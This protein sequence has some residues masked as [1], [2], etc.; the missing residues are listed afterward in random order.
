MAAV[1]AAQAT[2]TPVIADGGIRYSGDITKA[3]AAGAHAVMLGGLLAGLDESPGQRILYRG[4]VYKA[5]RGM[6]SLG[7][8]VQGSSER[9]RQG[10]TH[11]PEKLVPEGVEGRVP[12]RGPLGPFV[13]QLVG[14]LKAGM[15]YCGAR[16]IEELRSKARFIQVSVAGV[17]ESHPH[18]ITIT[19]ESP[20]YSI[21]YT[22][23]EH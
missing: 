13:Y 8:M 5:Y 12:Y 2:G 14:G 9:Y 21:D 10:E 6:G 22:G 1:E 7:A 23:E 19:Q 20:N 4:R 16:N 18:D 17:R 3:L 11:Q 15:G